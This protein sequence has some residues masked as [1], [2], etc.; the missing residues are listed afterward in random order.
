MKH[1]KSRRRR[2]VV[3][4]SRLPELHHDQ[5]EH[6]VGIIKPD[7]NGPSLNEYKE[8]DSQS[9]VPGKVVCVILSLSLIFIVIIGFLIHAG[10]GLAK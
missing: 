9:W 2:A 1:R 3:P 5:G 8:D 10:F 7:R 4:P 6:I